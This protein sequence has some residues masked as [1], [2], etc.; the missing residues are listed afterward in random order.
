M[1]LEKKLS[2]LS[3]KH[4]ALATALVDARTKRKAKLSKF[5]AKTADLKKEATALELKAKEISMTV[6][7]A[8]LKA[9]FSKFVGQGK[10]NP[11]EIKEMDFTALASLP[12]TAVVVL[13]SS[14][15]KRSVSKD[16][17]QYGQSGKNEI[18]NAEMTPEQ[19]R[20]A[21]ELQKSG[22]KLVA[23]AEEPKEEPK[24]EPKKED[25]KELKSYALAEEDWKKCMESL[26]EV[27]SKLSAIGE[28][29]KEVQGEA[30]EM[31][32]AEDK[33]EEQEKKLAS[34]EDDKKEEPKKEEGK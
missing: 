19:M 30:E 9:Q 34:E 31:S 27:T 11:V 7:T 32:A 33:D 16:V 2:T 6:K 20:K 8:Q 12:D 14:Y 23:L 4:K 10:M 22:K 17:F 21:M 29:V 24:D 1:D 13:L 15:D 5:V 28:K 26:T 3:H 25:D 18:T